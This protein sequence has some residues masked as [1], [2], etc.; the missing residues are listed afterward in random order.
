MV[1]VTPYPKEKRLPDTKPKQ[2][3]YP[4]SVVKRTIGGHTWITENEKGNE[5]LS[6]I[7]P[8]GSKNIYHPDGSK[9][10]HITGKAIQSYKSGLTVSSDENCDLKITGHGCI[11]VSGGIHIEVVGDAQIAV[12][13]DA[14]MAV[15]KNFAVGAENIYMGARGNMN[16]NVEGN[17]SAD[18][19][20]TSAI[21]SDGNMT[22]ATKGAMA[23]SADGA[24][25]DKG[26]VV[27]HNS[28]GSQTGS[29]AVTANRY[30]AGP[31]TT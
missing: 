5:S 12:S 6:Y 8:A 10:E 14:V 15:A 30:T 31:P 16:L 24:V 26:S 9:T 17:F 7:H 11:Q 28:S 21:V 20:G 2:S 19:K 23:R 22:L 4:L 1:A 3:P 13:G 29:Q 25:S 27:H 18:I